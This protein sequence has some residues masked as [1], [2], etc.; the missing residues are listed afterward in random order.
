MRLYHFTCSDGLVGIKLQGIRGG[1]L[2]IFSGDRVRFRPGF[3]W[4]TSNP[5]WSGQRWADQVEL[6][7]D[8]TEYRFTVDLPDRPLYGT[9]RDWQATK[10]LLRLLGCDE[11]AIRE[12]YERPGSDSWWTFEGMV[13]RG[14]IVGCKQNPRRLQ[15]EAHP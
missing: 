2:S 8:R 10:T 15:I 13:P 9:L 11:E 14:C 4:L 3:Q 5:E 6:K 1:S 7:C 12:G